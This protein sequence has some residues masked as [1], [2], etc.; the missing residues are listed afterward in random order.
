MNVEDDEVP[1]APT[2]REREREPARRGEKGK[3]ETKT[4][5]K[6]NKTKPGERA[7]LLP[8]T[9]TAGGVAVLLGYRRRGLDA[10]TWTEIASDLDTHAMPSGRATAPQ[11]AAARAGHAAAMGLLGTALQIRAVLTADARVRMRD[12]VAY[13][14]RVRPEHA[15]VVDLYNN[16]ARYVASTFVRDADRSLLACP[17]ALLAFTKVQWVPLAELRPRVEFAGVSDAAR[18]AFSEDAA[19]RHLAPRTIEVLRH[20]IPALESFAAVP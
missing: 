7:Y 8:Y 14:L 11:D 1:P 4:K 18:A 15:G 5:T 10:H 2:E 17:P 12:G 20:V 3:G 13:L 19:R 9:V 6:T 16:A